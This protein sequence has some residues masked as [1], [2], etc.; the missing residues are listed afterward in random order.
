MRL[1]PALHGASAMKLESERFGTLELPDGDAIRFPSG[2]VGF[3]REQEF[4]LLRR[5]GSDLVAW[6]HSTASPA[7][8]FPVVSAHGFGAAY[9]D[10]PLPSAALATVGGSA[11]EVAVLAV[12]SAPS[13]GPATVNLMA[14]LIVNAATRIGVQVL[15]DGTR[16]STR[17]LYVTEASEAGAE[18][19]P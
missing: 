11:E 15:L 4:V 13:G 5:E 3:P 8:A 14:P 18:V 16:F 6:L 7:L 9:P 12:L 19:A 2:L 10:V 17:E 1:A